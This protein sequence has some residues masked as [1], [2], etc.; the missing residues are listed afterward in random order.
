MHWIGNIREGRLEREATE[1][2]V[3]ERRYN[4]VYNVNIKI[5]ILMPSQTNILQT[6][7][8]KQ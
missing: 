1:L 8:L 6:R 3:P 4:P 7:I 5:L 2:L